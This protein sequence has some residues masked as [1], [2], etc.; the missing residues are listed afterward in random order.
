GPAGPPTEPLA[1]QGPIVPP[2]ARAPGLFRFALEGRQ[3]PALFVGG[4]LGTIVGS[5]VA[6]VG[7]LSSPSL[8][9][10][11]LLVA[12]LALL[13]VGLVLLGGSQAIERRAAG[14]A[15][16]GPSP[17]L[18]FAAIV[19]ITL[20]VAAVVGTILDTLGV[21]LDQDRPLGDLISV[22]LQGAVFVG[23]VRLLV[24]GPGATTW[25]EM[26]LTADPRRIANG[27]LN[28]AVFAL[29]VIV[30]T[31]LVAAVLV[32]LIGA[33]PPSP[34]P[35]T[36]T[37]SGLGLHLLAG[38]G[39][40]PFSEEVV[41]RGAALTA[42]LRTVGPRGAILRSAML[43]AAAH[44]LGISGTSFGDAAGLALVASLARLPVAIALGWIYVRTGTIW[45]S[46]GLHAAF[47][48]VLI[49]V[50]EAGLAAPT[51]MFWG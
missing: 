49:V 11:I 43:F 7:L 3:A 19:A 1:P 12:G 45:A 46:I 41:F 27:L 50:S 47:N 40:A 30:L 20:V 24:V 39:I 4:W 48:A 6:L 10:A 29:P 34:L 31:A 14:E 26:G 5:A 37:A 2:A 44:A 17:V 33:T 32:P 18:L 9:T 36:G 8:A 23:V 38:A 42:W 13:S 35:P 28:G 25:A 51:A 16:A 22:A 21:S 15:Y